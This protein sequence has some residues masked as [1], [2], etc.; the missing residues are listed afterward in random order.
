V[1]KPAQNKIK[2]VAKEASL[3]F[4]DV[5]KN[6]FPEVKT[7]DMDPLMVAQWTLRTQIFIQEWLNNNWPE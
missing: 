7:G 4:W 6:Y 2:A 3:A 5:V 1:E